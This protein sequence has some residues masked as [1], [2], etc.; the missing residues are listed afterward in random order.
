MLTR[1][2]EEI[3]RSVAEAGGGKFVMAGGANRAGATIAEELDSLEKSIVE[4]E[5]SS[6]KV[7]RFQWFAGLSVLLLALA[8]LIPERGGRRWFQ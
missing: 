8:R 7:E 2:D 1:V 4:S 6:A 3:L 5:I